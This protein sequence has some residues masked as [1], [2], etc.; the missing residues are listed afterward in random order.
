M[1]S[2]RVPAH[3]AAGRK[4]DVKPDPE[5]DLT[6]EQPIEAIEPATRA[7][8]AP[9]QK[10]GLQR[11]ELTAAAPRY[12]VRGPAGEITLA[13]ACSIPEFLA[14]GYTLADFEPATEQEIE[15]VNNGHGHGQL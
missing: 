1:P 8:R 10:A 6:P 5:V 3:A 2:D 14:A 7:H 11:S 9:E 15:A 4:P 13:Y 12:A